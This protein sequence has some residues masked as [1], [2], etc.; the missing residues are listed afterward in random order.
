MCLIIRRETFR[1]YILMNETDFFGQPL[2]SNFN[3]EKRKGPHIKMMINYERLIISRL[4]P[5]IELGN[6]CLGDEKSFENLESRC[7]FDKHR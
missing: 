4:E 3:G 2:Y 7:T 5:R 1:K 6:Y